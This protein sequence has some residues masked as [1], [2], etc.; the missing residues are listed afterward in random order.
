MPEATNWRISC[1]GQLR[2]TAL[3]KAELHSHLSKIRMTPAKGREDW[4]YVAEGS[5]NLLGTGSNAPAVGLA[6]CLVLPFSVE[7]IRLAA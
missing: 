6:N 3:A 1:D 2:D 5:W 7:L 4:H